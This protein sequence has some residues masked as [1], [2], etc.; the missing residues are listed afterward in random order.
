ML[1]SLFSKKGTERFVSVDVGT[2]A[3]KLMEL[4]VSGS[5]PKLVSIA[6]S[7]TPGGSITNNQITKADQ[8]AGAIRSLLDANDIAAE[9][10]VMCLPGPTAFTKKVVLGMT[11]AKDLAENIYFEAS[12]YIP[13]K[14]E[15]VH[16][17]YQV[18]RVVNSA[19][20]EVLLVAVKNE[21]IGSYID[22]ISQTGLQPAIG[23]IDYFALQNMFELN[24][25]EELSKTNAIVNVGAR[26]TSVNIIQDGQS[27]FTGDVSVGG[28]LYTDALCETLGLEPRAAERAKMGQIPEGVDA[29]LVTETLDRT[30]EHVATELHRQIGFFWNAAATDRSIDTIYLSGGGALSPGLVDELATKTG[31]PCVLLD[32]FRNVDTSAGFDADFLSEV[33][34]QMA[35]SVGLAIRRFADKKQIID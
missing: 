26:Y 7:A 20:I 2:S 33:S 35:V 3:I 31:L 8:I 27:L 10:A 12:N 18:L 6:S 16:L 25:P 23:D 15:Q 28:R 21:I 29:N 14:V 1:G 22:A 17:D 30:T 11:R 19:S 9:K 24:Y 32:P 4:D 13:H 5:K 34:S